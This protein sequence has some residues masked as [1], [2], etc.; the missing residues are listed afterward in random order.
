MSHSSGRFFSLLFLALLLAGLLRTAGAQ[1]QRYSIVDLGLFPG[2][3]ISYANGINASGQVTGYASLSS[4]PYRAFRT[5]AAGKI[6]ADTDLGT[7]PGGAYSAGSGINASGQ[8]TGVT[9]V[10]D[11]TAHAF[12]TTAGGQDQR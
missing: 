7:F 12:R 5:P 3:T 2:G 11:V 8:V 1:A 6:S 4:G 9:G 10:D